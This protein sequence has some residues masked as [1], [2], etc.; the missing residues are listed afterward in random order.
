MRLATRKATRGGI[1]AIMSESARNSRWRVSEERVFGTV[2]VRLEILNEPT[3]S[4]VGRSL[5]RQFL[6]FLLGDTADPSYSPSR[7]V[8]VRADRPTRPE[9]IDYGHDYEAAQVGFAQVV[10]DAEGQSPEKNGH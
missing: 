10:K 4:A 9:V 5:G 2:T 8:C 7:V 3:S 6:L 1:V